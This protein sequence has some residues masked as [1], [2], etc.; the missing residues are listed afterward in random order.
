M[1][2]DILYFDGCPHHGPTVALVREVVRDL[3]IQS[4]VNEIEVSSDDAAR[5]QFL[6]S[7]TVRVDGRDIETGEVKRR[8]FSMSCRWYGDSGVPP[9]ALIEKALR[10]RSQD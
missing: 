2:I 6:G 4:A 7:P 8:V 10:A 1:R 5:H 3:G 9:R